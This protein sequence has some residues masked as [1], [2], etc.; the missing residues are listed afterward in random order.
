MHAMLRVGQKER[1]K[2]ALHPLNKLPSGVIWTTRV[3]Y[4]AIL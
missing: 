2:N 3:L 1:E 4:I